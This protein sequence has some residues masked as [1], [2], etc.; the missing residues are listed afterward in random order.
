[1]VDRITVSGDTKDLKVQIFHQIP[2]GTIGKDIPVIYRHFMLFFTLD[3]YTYI[4]E[5]K[6]KHRLNWKYN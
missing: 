6:T 1:M 4:C 3:R 2:I 5:S